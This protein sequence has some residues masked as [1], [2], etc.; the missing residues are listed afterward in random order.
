MRTHLEFR[1]EALREAF[2]RTD[3]P[4]EIGGRL[5]AELLSSRL[6]EHGFAVKRVVQEDWGWC[7]VLDNEAFSLWIGTG[8]YLEY[9]DGHLCF[10]EPSRPFV[11]RWFRQVSTAETVERLATAI[12]AII[13]AS[14]QASE[15]RW[16]NETEVARG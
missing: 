5:V 8:D 15:L 4:G 9:S 12:E 14:G 16:W 11:R 6:P 13:R 7:I 1:S 3:D 10:I 2:N